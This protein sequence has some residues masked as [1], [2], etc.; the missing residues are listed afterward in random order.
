MRSNEKEGDVQLTDPTEL[1][2]SLETDERFASPDLQSQQERMER[3]LA[4]T[5]STLPPLQREALI[6]HY[7]EG[8]S[9]KEVA[10]ITGSEVDAVYKRLSK[11]RESLKARFETIAQTQASSGLAKTLVAGPVLKVAFEKE[12]QL[13]A[14]DSIRGAVWANLSLPTPSVPAPSG[15]GAETIKGASG[16]VKVAVAVAV[17][18]I[19]A[20]G[21]Y[22]AANRA[23]VQQPSSQIS[24][25]PAAIQNNSTPAD[26]TAAN[27]DATTAGVDADT[28]P[29]SAT[30]V[31]P[32]GVSSSTPAQN[33]PSK[34][35][36]T[37]NIHPTI[38]VAEPSVRYPVGAKVSLKK[39]L[40]DAY[41]FAVDSRGREIAFETK[42]YGDIDFAKAGTYF[43]KINAK[44]ASGL[45]A[46]LVKIKV[47]I[48]TNH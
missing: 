43:L 36:Q 8:F 12:A 41:V 1:S 33:P 48:S 39:I 35:S 26:S 5:V 42:G 20:T 45:A 28:H 2:A 7:Y 16:E 15:V 18:G 13:V 40:A 27:D 6:L 22:L 14:T 3:E 24:P 4:A 47:V 23:P 11:G 31:A 29:T 30:G 46:K 32:G 9:G 19:L 21:I 10:E 34:A 37:E 17:L 38:V 44:D 25:P